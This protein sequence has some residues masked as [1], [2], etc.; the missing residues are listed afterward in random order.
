M[1][2]HSCWNLKCIVVGSHC[3]PTDS[4]NS[5]NNANDTK[6]MSTDVK[7]AHYWLRQAKHQRRQPV[8]WAKTG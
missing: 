4:A 7:M 1:V 2:T 5:A 6:N 8:A 3:D